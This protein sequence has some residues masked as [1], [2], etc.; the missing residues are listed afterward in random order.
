MR[1]GVNKSELGVCDAA[2]ETVRLQ[3]IRVRDDLTSQGQ[4]DA[5]IQRVCSHYHVVY[6]AV[7]GSHSTQRATR[8]YWLFG[9]I[10]WTP[11]HT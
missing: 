10:N 9:Q 7:I 3:A 11:G 5:W 8:T 1:D 6:A 2:V 4:V